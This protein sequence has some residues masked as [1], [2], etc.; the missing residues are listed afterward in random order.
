MESDAYK[1]GQMFGGILA[2]VMMLAIPT[3]FIL[4]LIRYLITRKTGWLVSCIISGVLGLLFL[5]PIVFIGAR[6]WKK[7]SDRAKAAIEERN[8]GGRT[9]RTPGGE[10]VL[11]LPSSWKPMKTLHDDAV[12]QEA[13]LG[14]GCFLIILEDSK[15]DFTGTLADFSELT[16]NSIL[17]NLEKSQRVAVRGLG[18]SDDI[19]AYQY[20]IEG[21]ANHIAMSY[22]FT[23]VESKDKFHQILIWSSMSSKEKVEPEIKRILSSLRIEQ[24]E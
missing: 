11:Q 4:S 17:N 10:I 1:M 23:A 7:G 24:P 12:M 15:E 3:L 13:N 9:A 21:S 16:S 20:R 14:E 19:K 5:L 18:L 22:V 8:G 2:I 6:A